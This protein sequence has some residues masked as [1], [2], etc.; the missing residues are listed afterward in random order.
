MQERLH[1]PDRR[2]EL[3]EIVPLADTTIYE[4]EQRGEFP[5]RFFLT[6]RCVVW[7]LAEVEAW[8]E[9][10]RQASES[11]TIRRAPSPDVRKRKTRPVRR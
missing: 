7:D 3:R 9:E 11:A 2:T 6:P 5:R 1:P 8:I 4:L 10:R